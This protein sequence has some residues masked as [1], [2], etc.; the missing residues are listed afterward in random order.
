[1]NVI[2][3]ENVESPGFGLDLIRG[4][5]NIWLSFLSGL[6]SSLEGSSLLLSSLGGCSLAH[7]TLVY[8]E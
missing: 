4:N 6:F 3:E 2:T 8:P 1:M 7:L 5:E